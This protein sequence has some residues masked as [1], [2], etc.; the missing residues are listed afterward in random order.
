METIKIIHWRDGTTTIRLKDVPIGTYL[1]RTPTAKAVYERGE[2]DRASKR[3]IVDDC[4]D[5]SRC[6]YLKGSTIVYVGFTY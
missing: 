1:K 6:L 2:Y 5:I 3:Y 4:S